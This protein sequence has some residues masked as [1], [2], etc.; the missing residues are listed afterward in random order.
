MIEK[1]KRKKKGIFAYRP[2]FAF[3]PVLAEMGWNGSEW[4]GIWDKME[5]EV[6]CPGLL[7]SLRNSDCSSQN[8]AKLITMI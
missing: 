6:S 4:T 2:K 8:G 3:W 5:W 7:T 1:K